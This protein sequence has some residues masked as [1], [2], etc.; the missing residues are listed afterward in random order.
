MARFQKP[1]WASESTASSATNRASAPKQGQGRF[2]RHS[3]SGRAQVRCCALWCT[4]GVSRAAPNPLMQPR[5]ED[6]Y[7]S[8]LTDL[9]HAVWAHCLGPSAS[10]L[11]PLAGRPRATHGAPVGLVG[12]T[13]SGWRTQRLGAA[14]DASY[15]PRGLKHLRTVS[16]RRD[17]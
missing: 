2:L 13:S 16:G 15:T 6:H 7:A 4:A 3:Q 17:P 1:G 14:P 9:W 5:Q 11:S 8:V 12:W 10:A